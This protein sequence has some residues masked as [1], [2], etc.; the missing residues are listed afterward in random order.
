MPARG[1][2][3]GGA[4][5]GD[6]APLALPS[7]S[8]LGQRHLERRHFVPECRLGRTEC[9]QPLLELRAAGAR[10]LGLV[11]HPV[12]QLRALQLEALAPLALVA[13]QLHQLRNLGGG[14]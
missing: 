2:A 6:C 10:I 14:E 3:D 12:G 8:H 7:R 4:G 13:Q 11:V 5:G 1:K 9:P